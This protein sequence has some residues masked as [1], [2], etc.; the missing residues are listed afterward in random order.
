[1]NKAVFIP[2]V[3]VSMASYAA[4]RPAD[5]SFVNDPATG[6]MTNL[7]VGADTFGMNFVHQ[8]NGRDFP[9]SLGPRFRWGLGSVKVDGR[10]CAW[11][12]PSGADGGRLVYRPAE[13][14]EVRVERRADGGDLVER[15]E[16]ANVSSRTLALSEIDVYTTFNDNYKPVEELRTRRCHAHVWAGENAG[17]LAAMRMGGRP[18]HLGLMATEGRISAYELKERGLDKGGSDTRGVICL[19]PPDSVLKPG[20]STAVGWRIFAHDG[21]DGFKAGILARGGVW[22]EASSYVVSRGET[23]RITFEA[24]GAAIFGDVSAS[25]DG[26]ELPVARKGKTCA[27]DYAYVRDGNVR[28]EFRYGNGKMTHVE[29][30]GVGDERALVDARVRYL[31]KHQIYHAPG[32]PQDGAFLPYDPETDSLVQEWRVPK[33]S[34]RVD[35]SE[36]SERLGIGVF[37]ARYAQLGA[38]EKALVMPALRAY[39]R[40]VQT[41]LI[42][43]DG[44]IWGSTA[45]PW[46]YRRYDFPWAALFFAEM[47]R[48]TGDVAFAKEAGRQQRNAYRDIGTLNLVASSEKDVALAVRDAGMGREFE[49]L[50]GLYRAHKDAIMRSS[51]LTTREVGTAPECCSG[52]MMQFLQTGELTGESAYGRYVLSEWLPEFEACLG[53]QPSWCSHDIGL[54]HWDGYWFGKLRMWGDT[55]PQDWNGTEAESFREIARATG[56]RRYEARAPAVVRQ[57]LGLFEPD[58]RAHCVF[59]CPDRVDGRPGKVFDPL[60]NDQDWALAFYLKEMQVGGGK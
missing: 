43:G 13:G 14:L 60:M 40:F 10:P 36:G 55:L 29:I 1:M 35:L 3:F 8:A 38:A 25:A 52:I 12:K 24:S 59:I 58:G 27:V 9:A 15:Y 21:W 51:E 45:R 39:A 37:L 11:E 4:C 5:V 44:T 56:D 53:R 30:L 33:A 54:H 18:P 31:L 42:D 2:L 32:E 16:F 50:V 7:C 49:E 28:V 6:G 46:R 17:W 48:V 23:S 41:A 22:A 19:S 47:F 34:R 57:T 20:E 26:M